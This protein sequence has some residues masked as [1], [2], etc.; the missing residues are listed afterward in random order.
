MRKAPKKRRKKLTTKAILGLIFVLAFIVIFVC[1]GITSRYIDDF[2]DSHYGTAF[3]LTHTASDYID[4]EKAAGY[5]ET[6]K[7][8][9]YYGQ[10]HDFLNLMRVEGDLDRLYVFVPLENAFV[11]LWDTDSTAGNA[12]GVRQAF[13]GEFKENAMSAFS[14]KAEENAYLKGNEGNNTETIIT[15]VIGILLGIGVGALMGYV[16]IRFIEMPHA[17]FVRTPYVLG[18]L[19]SAAITAVFSVAINAFGTRKVKDLKLTD[20]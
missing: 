14:V 1:I 18:W 9:D 3:V 11:T 12:L 4:S 13:E 7:T 8:D 5:Y 2:D 16:V 10:V 6:G 19:I 15:S 17:Q 20:A